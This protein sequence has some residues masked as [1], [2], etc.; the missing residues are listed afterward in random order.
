MTA[1]TLWTTMAPEV[2]RV[3]SDYWLGSGFAPPP[4]RLHKPTLS[5]GAVFICPVGSPWVRGFV[6]ANQ[7][8][9]QLFFEN[10]GDEVADSDPG[11]FGFWGAFSAIYRTDIGQPQGRPVVPV[12]L[13]PLPKPPQLPRRGRR[14]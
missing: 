1:A 5:G 14:M 6:Q 4:I 10:Q 7:E 8:H 13:S 2:Y 12:P 3:W 9:A 11:N